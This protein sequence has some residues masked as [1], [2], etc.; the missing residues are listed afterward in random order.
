M[1]NIQLHPSTLSQKVMS[2]TFLQ[3]QKPGSLE[4]KDVS[5]LLSTSLKQ[6]SR[7]IAL[8]I[9]AICVLPSTSIMKALRGK[10]S[11]KKS[12]LLLGIFTTAKHC[13]F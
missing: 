6:W 3:K 8:M 11:G 1:G 7:L 13:G 10:G 12:G 9:Y 4:S 2:L 5:G